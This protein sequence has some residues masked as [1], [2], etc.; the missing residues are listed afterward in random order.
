MPLRCVLFPFKF[1]ANKPTEN[2]I[3]SSTEMHTNKS[4]EEEEEP[5]DG[6][7]ERRITTK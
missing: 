3:N 7:E 5:E 2:P 4:K 1:V 6:E